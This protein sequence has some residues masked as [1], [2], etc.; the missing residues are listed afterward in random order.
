MHSKLCTLNQYILLIN[1]LNMHAAIN[2]HI[3]VYKIY[4][5]MFRYAQYA[6]QVQ[7]YS[8]CSDI[9]NIYIYIYYIHIDILNMLCRY[10]ERG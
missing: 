10:P 4:R 3:Y 2:K 9:L 8:I 6:L 7:I 5:Y 1:A